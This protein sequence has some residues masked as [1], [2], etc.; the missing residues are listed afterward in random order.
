MTRL[1]PASAPL[2]ERDTE[3]EAIHDGI[4]AAAG[5][6]GRLLVVEGRAGIGKSRL[7]GEA[8]AIAADRGLE[9][10]T[11]C[12]TEAE[13]SFP[14]GVA[15]QLLEVRMRR[16]GAGERAALLEGV[17]GI[18]AELF[19]G[20]AWTRLSSD[21]NAVFSL[22]HGLHWLV[23]NLA[24]RRPL[25]LVVDDVR[26]ADTASLR[27]L[28]F[29]AQRIADLPVVLVVALRTGEPAPERPEVTALTRHPA[30]TVLTPA[31][32]TEHGVAAIVRAAHAGA[33]EEFCARCARATGGVPFLLNELLL[34]LAD[35][36]IA[37]TSEMA[38]AIDAITP[39]GVLRSVVVRLSRFPAGA[40][41]VARATA[42]LG[43]D[44]ADPEHLAAVARIAS[45]D[46]VV[47]A[48]AA[49][50]EAGIFAPD[51][52]L[53]F[54]H[55][56]LRSA[57]YDDLGAAERGRLHARAAA[58]LHEAG[59]RDEQIAA[60]LLSAPPA[61]ADWAVAAL[62]SAA[63]HNVAQGAPGA[64]VRCL[65]R[66]L[67]EPAGDD[68]RRAMTVELGRAE[69]AAGLEAGIERLEGLVGELGARDGAEVLAEL[70][71]FHHT[72]GRPAEAA[73]AFER[74]VALAGEREDALAH[75]LRAGR[76]LAA[77]W[78]PAM[79][80]AALAGV[81]PLLDRSR[82]PDTLGE[83]LLLL[84]L[85]TGDVFSAA[86]RERGVAL[87]VR[88]WGGGA[89]VADG[90][91]AHPALSHLVGAL[92]HS[93][94]FALAEEVCDAL[95]AETARLG[96][97]LA[98]ANASYLRG[99]MLYHHG[100][101]PEAAGDLEL[102]LEVEPLG[103]DFYGPT[104]RALLARCWMLRDEPEA[105]GRLVE[106]PP[107]HAD[108]AHRSPLWAAFWLA[109]AALALPG[110]PQDAY[111][112]AVRAGGMLES[113]GMLNPALF[114]WRS[115][116]A[117]ALARLGDLD[118]ARELAGE[119]LELAERYGAPRAIAVAAR[120]RG[121]IEPGD[122]GLPWLERAVEAAQRSPAYVA[123]AE[124]LLALG[125][126]VRRQRGPKAAIE[127]LREAMAVAD[128]AG[129]TALVEQ[130]RSEVV[131]AGGRPRRAA[132]TGVAAL[133]PGELRVARLAAEGRTNREI[134]EALF[135]TRK[136]VDWHL[137]G[138]YRK[139]GVNTRDALGPLL[140]AGGDASPGRAVRAAR[141][142][143]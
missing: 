17:A 22:V 29:L 118:R 50:S 54:A 5:G 18:A 125:S 63:A 138:A 141:M 85:S 98:F 77:M 1:G 47:D 64:A 87:A 122:A 97:P 95:V 111:D 25:A 91:A 130:A 133:T 21:P 76:A 46:A 11:A 70:G 90:G 56:L 88:A 105:A 134:A 121:L 61:R 19:D 45:A 124:A 8:E 66:A 106:I 44:G 68:E 128:R 20:R 93:D 3:V 101:I 115:P 80:D 67:D 139:L 103:W 81:A 24:E 126:V 2:V 33:A 89:L 35:E 108:A 72:Q 140:A 62:R 131:A 38:P 86:D 42:V 102:A 9:V 59:A 14:F 60:Q 96:Q 15:L 142:P 69:L 16:A 37:P 136:T 10:L 137:R 109:R 48:A 75:E 26:W 23:A 100:R 49:L 6:A 73:A 36:Q 92:S 32:L 43:G 78:D 83:R 117:L 65:Q 31:P 104:A 116:A 114:A 4:E 135:V 13:E 129:A 79:R 82:E 132:R 113:L 34:A 41:E 52:H 71:R 107:E 120:A 74:G 55:P 39:E 127:T 30:A 110:R 112:Q 7:L 123:R 53:A 119:E 84:A 143:D 94:E 12:G 40:V 57:V 99:A 28:S 51:G 58:V 27:L